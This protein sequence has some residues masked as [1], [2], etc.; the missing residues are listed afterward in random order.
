MRSTSPAVDALLR[1][2][3]VLGFQPD[4]LMARELHVSGCRYQ[5][6]RHV[7]TLIAVVH[8]MSPA[9]AQTPLAQR[10]ARPRPPS[11]QV[12]VARDFSGSPV[13]PVR[14]INHWPL[15]EQRTTAAQGTPSEG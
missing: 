5:M 11:S 3:K 8:L 6:T 10:R 15:T 12:V 7:V 1:V 4:E 13:K 9:S 2:T 14:V